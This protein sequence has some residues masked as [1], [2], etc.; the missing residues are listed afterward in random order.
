MSYG[1][2]LRAG[3]VCL[4][5]VETELCLAHAFMAWRMMISNG[6]VVVELRYI[7]GLGVGV[8]SETI[9]T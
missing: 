8:V 1:L 7:I 5:E 3:S 2:E 9:R 4:W 6:R